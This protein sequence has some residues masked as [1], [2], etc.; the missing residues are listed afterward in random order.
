MRALLHTEFV[1]LLAR[2]DISQAS[3][4]RLA[5]ISAR[6][7]NNWCRGRATVPRWAAVLAILLEDNPPESLEM[8]IEEVQFSWHETL[9]IPPSADAATA[10]SAL[11]KLALIYHPDQGG[12]QAQMTRINAAYARANP[13][14][15]QPDLRGSPPDASQPMLSLKR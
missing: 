14:D 4:A 15:N 11:T 13:K 10:R 9:G 8:L 6:Q 2:A 1:A 5:G 3:L 12:A 7:V